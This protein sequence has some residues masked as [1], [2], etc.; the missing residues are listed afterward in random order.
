MSRVRLCRVASSPAS[1]RPTAYTALRVCVCT[2]HP[3]GRLAVVC[4]LYLLRSV[5]GAPYLE[6][7][8]PSLASFCFIAHGPPWQRRGQEKPQADQSRAPWHHRLSPTA[9][10]A[11]CTIVH[12][13]VAP[14]RAPR[15]QG[16]H[17]R[18]WPRP[19]L[20]Q[21]RCSAALAVMK[22]VRV[23]RK[24]RWL[25]RFEQCALIL[26][27]HRQIETKRNADRVASSQRPLTPRTAWHPSIAIL[28]A[29]CCR[30]AIHLL[31]LPPGTVPGS[32]SRGSSIFASAPWPA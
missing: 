14:E 9:G 18:R 6:I 26:R 7:A 20:K 32:G 12:G 13:S 21:A 5:L 3:N 1:A 4:G 19:R 27:S 24:R 11:V 2:S 16:P 30:H 25:C 29:D 22:I 23:E 17:H 15:E 31:H 10:Q 8:A 28:L